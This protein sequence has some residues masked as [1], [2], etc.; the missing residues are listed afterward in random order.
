MWVRMLDVISSHYILLECEHLLSFTRWLYYQV[1]QGLEQAKSKFSKR[2]RLKSD[3]AHGANQ[4]R[5]VS[6]GQLII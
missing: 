4:S 2:I 6:K 5:V 1:G 3:K